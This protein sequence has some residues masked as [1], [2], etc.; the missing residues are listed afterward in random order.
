[1]KKILRRKKASNGNG[2][3]MPVHMIFVCVSNRVRSVFSEFLFQKMLAERSERFIS[4]V[5]VSSAGF[6][7]QKLRDQLAQMHVRF[8]DPFY[9]RPMA[10][11][12]RAALLKKGIVVSTGW[13]SKGLSPEMMDDA[14]LI[15][16][17]LPQ[18]KEEL[19]NLFPKARPKIST[20]REMS[21]WDEYLI[22][23]DFTGLPLDNTFW[24]YVEENPD[25][26]SKI[27]LETEETLVR[28]FPNILRQLGLES[29]E[30]QE[31]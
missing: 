10:E 24:D 31:A 17:A 4:E 21:K 14:D 18:Q 28:A 23:E 5:K 11:T 20:A 29:G 30:K 1:M 26:V 25:Y 7:P 16:T 3:K 22:S 8:P 13:R 27:I 19:I 2:V 9:N 6:I 12:A 15:I